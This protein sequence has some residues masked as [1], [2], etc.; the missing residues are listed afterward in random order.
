MST[1]ADVPSAPSVEQSVIVSGRDRG[2]GCGLDCDFEGRGSFGERG[3]YGGR[4]IGF[5]KEA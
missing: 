2:H 3:S 4:H 5:D 1:G